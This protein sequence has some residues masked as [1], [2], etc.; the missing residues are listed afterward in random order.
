MSSDHSAVRELT[1]V[2]RAVID[3]VA[4]QM[5]HNPYD[6]YE[7]LRAAGPFVPGPHDTQLVTRHADAQ[8]ILQDARWSH[9]EEPDLLH[10]DSDVE[11]PGSFLWMEPPDHTRLR[12]L[13]GKAF[14]ART[15]HGL[16]ERAEQLVDDLLSHMLA[17]GDVE[18][19]EALAYPVPLT[20]ICELLGV[21]AEAH[22]RVRAMSAG[23]AR[24]LDPDL[25]LSPEDLAARTA[26]VHEFTEF[27]GDLVEQ[28]RRAPRAD[29]ITALV[30]AEESGVRLTPTELIGT[31]LILVVAGHET[32]VNL[33]GNGV[34][35]LIRHPAEF[36]RLCDHPELSASAVDEVLRYDPP[37]HLTTRTA[38][39]EIT[40]GGRTFTP[41]EAVIVLL[42]S[43]N[44][45]PAAFPVADRFDITRFQPGHR[46]E[47]H[48][49]FGLGLHYCLGAPLARLEMQTV[50]RAIAT[51]VR[52]L[53]LLEEPPYRPNVV[54]R[55][56]SQLR[57][58]LEGR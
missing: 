49:S 44:R 2:Q 26:A 13:V 56:M 9:A 25:L 32:T 39:D 55:G 15:V 14:T 6:S 57:V 53:T 58:H 35:A 50:L 46:P 29:L 5:R 11:L 37:V 20:L 10:G 7:I 47:R 23:I 54:V 45:D 16:R 30:Q 51:R 27:F 18:V 28:R 22:Q 24:G 36:R 4:P 41:G 12:G 43:A 38:H 42:G 1:P 31:L 34:L 8:A 48:L 52:S 21:P 40:V 19:L 3:S 33:I 17:D